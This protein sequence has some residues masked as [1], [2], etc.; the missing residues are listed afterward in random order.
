MLKLGGEATL[1]EFTE[2]LLGRLPVKR[3]RLRWRIRRSTTASLWRA[4]P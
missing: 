4:T 1:T 3:T 2:K